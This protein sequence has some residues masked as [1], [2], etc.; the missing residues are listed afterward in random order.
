L[1]CPLDQHDLATFR[2]LERQ[3]VTAAPQLPS[4]IAREFLH[5]EWPDRK[6]AAFR[7]AAGQVV[8]IVRPA[9]ASH[10]WHALAFK[11]VDHLGTLP[12][13]HVLARSRCRRAEIADSSIE[14]GPT[15]LITVVDALAR[16]QWMVGN[17]ED[18]A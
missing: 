2:A 6:R 4:P 12:Q 15:L 18:T 13:E 10:E 8:M 14:I 17:P 1:H 3:A 11:V 16:L 5:V 9:I 7:H